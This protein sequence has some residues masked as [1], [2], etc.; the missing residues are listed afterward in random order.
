MTHPETLELFN[1][2]EKGAKY[3]LFFLTKVPN[4][5]HSYWEYAVEYQD[6]EDSDRF[7]VGRCDMIRGHLLFDVTNTNLRAHGLSHSALL[8]IG[9]WI[10]DNQVP[11][12]EL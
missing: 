1:I 2:G 11:I 9:K 3:D 5:D 7:E 8:L 12:E 10:A 6:F 4:P